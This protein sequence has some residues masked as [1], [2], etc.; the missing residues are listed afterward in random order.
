V[1]Q[2]IPDT[3]SAY[4][5]AMSNLPR[6]ILTALTVQHRSVKE[7]CTT[8]GVSR[9]WAYEL[10][11]RYRAEGDAAL[12]PRSRRP[13]TSPRALD[14]D[15]V[16]AILAWRTRLLQAG[17]DAGPATIAHHLA[18]DG[19]TVSEATIWRTLH[20]HG[21]ITPEPN[22]RPKSSYIRF[23]A[24]APNECWQSDF[25]H[26]RLADGTDTEVLTFLDDHSRFALSVTAH[27]P[28]TGPVV[29][30]TFT[31]ATAIHGIPA[32]VLTDN[33]L[34]YTTRS[35]GA[36]NAFQ[37][38]L[39]TLGVHQKNGAPHH[40]QTQGKVERFQQTLKKHLTT[41]EPAATLEQLQTQLDTFVTY[42]NN[43]RP[44]RSL[45]R[46]TP[47]AAYLA[48]PKALPIGSP[49]GRD[50]R[51]RTDKIDGQ[52]KVTLRYSGHLYKIGIGR[53]HARTPIVMLIQDLHITIAAAATGE[54]LRQLTLDTSR[55]YQPQ[56]TTKPEPS[57]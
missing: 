14:Q 37:R 38:L 46:R 8:Y 39:H 27:T 18:Q 52:G 5:L 36:R 3:V 16:T 1:S 40:P 47:R 44:H 28:V 7:V 53:T 2:D 24:N 19:V 34:V 54:I 10:L 35:L 11:A 49:A 51:V 42:Y 20:R 22:K 25:T 6:L 17:H 23:E 4:R 30:E 32:T 21:L 50:H 41:R 56:E 57:N 31:A 12:E 45:G 43:V 55:T 26:V 15:T 29:V 48:R 9:S 13:K 33:G